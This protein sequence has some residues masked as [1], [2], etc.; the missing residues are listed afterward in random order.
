V[1]L[2]AWGGGEAETLRTK[3]TG[4]SRNENIQRRNGKKS[5]GALGL[6]SQSQGIAGV[7]KGKTSRAEE[8]GLEGGGRRKLK[9]RLPRFKNFLGSER[10]PNRNDK[11]WGERD[12]LERYRTG[13]KGRSTAGQ[14]T[15]NRNRSGG[16][17]EKKKTRIAT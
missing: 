8:H 4:R 15:K 9:K 14:P 16:K 2:L 12:E 1:W 10:K 17:E 11:K 7:E 3:I 6:G 13:C 5:A